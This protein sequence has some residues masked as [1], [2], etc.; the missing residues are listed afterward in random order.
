MARTKTQSDELLDVMDTLRAENAAL[1]RQV[2][3]LS[4]ELANTHEIL[5][6]ERE[7]HEAQL[8]AL[9]VEL[10]AKTL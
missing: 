10:L 1:V 4:T 3:A 7:S 9:I 5:R 2:D 6:I 8:A